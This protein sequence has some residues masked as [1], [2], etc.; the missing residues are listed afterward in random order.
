VAGDAQ[1]TS[2]LLALQ[3]MNNMLKYD[4]NGKPIANDL[5]AHLWKLSI[6][7]KCQDEFGVG[8]NGIYSVFTA[9]SMFRMRLDR[10]G[11]V[12]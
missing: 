2:V 1:K 10:H 5:I 12:V 7:D 6:N 9:A 11:W 3:L 8:K 4:D